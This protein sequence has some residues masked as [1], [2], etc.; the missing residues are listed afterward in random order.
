MSGS[1]GVFLDRDGTLVHD[2]GFLRDPG[3]VALLPRAAPAL[4]RLSAA[5]WPA[6][7]VTNQ[8]A[9][10]RGLI[11]WDEYHAVERRITELLAAEGAALAATYVCPHYPESSGPCNCR[12]PGLALYR[13]AE[14]RFGIDLATSWWIGDQLTD[15]LP[16]KVLGGRGILVRTGNG[17]MAAEEARRKGFTV[18]EDLAAAVDLVLGCEAARS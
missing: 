16:G 14:A 11:S 17:A 6:I 1:P 7:V 10:A 15:L 8:S 2:P 5:G 3:D 18:A 9:I 4:A 13:A 12:K